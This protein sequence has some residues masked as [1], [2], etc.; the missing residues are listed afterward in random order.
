MSNINRTAAPNKLRA[1][2]CKATQGAAVFCKMLS[3]PYI[4]Q[5]CWHMQL[6]QQN[7]SALRST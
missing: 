2:A 7:D 3:K 6:L 1:L 5:K 4:K